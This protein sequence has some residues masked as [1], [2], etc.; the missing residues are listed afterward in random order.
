M[1]ICFPIEVKVREF[2]PKVF[3]C[4]QLLK[5]KKFKAVNIILGDKKYIGSVEDCKNLLYFSKGL[6]GK[7]W[8]QKIKDIRK[9]NFIFD[10]DEEGPVNVLRPDDSKIRLNK[11]EIERFDKVFLWGRSALK[12]YKKKFKN[13]FVKKYLLVTGHP[14]FDLLKKPYLGIYSEEVK[15]IKKEFKNFV[16]I[17]SN[18]SVDHITGDN[19]YY[20]YT[21]SLL[22]KNLNPN[23]KILNDYFFEEKR[24]YN[25]LVVLIKKLAE[26]NPNTNFIFR[27]HPTQDISK[28]KLTFKHASK[29]LFVIYKY[30]VTPWI[31][32]CNLFI[33]NDCMTSLEAVA[34]K[35]KIIKFHLTP[36]NNKITR[37]I[38]IGIHFYNL[39]KCLSFLNK[40][41]RNQARIKNEFNKFST[42]LV[43]NINKNYFTDKFMTFIKN[44]NFNLNKEIKIF[45]NTKYKKNS[46]IFLFFEKFKSILKFTM[47]KLRIYTKFVKFYNYNKLLSGKYKKSKVV[48]IKKEEINSIINVFSKLDKTKFYFTVKKINTNVFLISNQ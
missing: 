31:I 43:Y 29:N 20:E 35:K 41:F 30:T 27:P 4:Y 40:Y 48:Y 46:H 7:E 36:L 44:S 16:F 26:Q 37:S 9:R 17:P 34:L 45:K 21:V 22:K 33:H 15:K 2:I 11:N 42:D 28:V 47:I 10:L 25:E 24:N 38:N 32:A 8:D 39:E 23:I 6:W 19:N 1:N 14:K 13:D 18:F 5:K 12:I 3:L